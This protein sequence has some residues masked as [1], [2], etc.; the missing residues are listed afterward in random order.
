MRVFIGS[1]TDS[2][3]LVQ[4]IGAWIERA[5]HQP[6]PW[7][8]PDLFIAGDFVLE[9]LV[10]ISRTIDAAILVF[11]ES[12]R[13]GG[14]GER[15]TQPRDNVLIEYGLFIGALGK[16]NTIVCV[17]GNP[18]LPTD[19]GG[20]VTVDISAPARE[21]AENKVR[22]WLARV[23]PPPRQDTL[24]VELQ[25]L[26]RMRRLGIRDADVNLYLARLTYDEDLARGATDRGGTPNHPLGVLLERH[27]EKLKHDRV[28]LDLLRR[29]ARML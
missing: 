23:R 9:R 10:K 15:T 17:D 11:A 6:V 28:Y 25:I 4:M 7:N 22:N 8:G 18:K 19:L 12:D 27:H 20:V 13:V 2:L 14:P 24:R 5:G 1:S 21:Q 3:A 16:E 26:Q 29:I